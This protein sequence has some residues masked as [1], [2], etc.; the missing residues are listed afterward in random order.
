MSQ[1]T[2]TYDQ[3]MAT[4]QEKL[5]RLYAVPTIAENGQAFAAEFANIP[6]ALDDD[7]RYVPDIPD[8]DLQAHL[9]DEFD[10]VNRIVGD[11][12]TGYRIEACRWSDLTDD[13]KAVALSYTFYPVY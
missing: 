1:Q 7:V 9:E 6:K 2:I 4:E 11:K 3:A 13:E 10:T 12:L 5:Q 8:A